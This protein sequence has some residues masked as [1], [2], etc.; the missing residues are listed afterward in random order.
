MIGVF[1]TAS[2]KVEELPFDLRPKRLMT[3]QLTASDDKAKVRAKLVDALAA[4]IKQCIGDTE[5]DRIRRNSRI[6]SV[7]SELW[8]FG[9]EIEEWYGIR[10]LPE[11]IQNQLSAAQELPD[12]MRRSTYAEML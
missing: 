7:L 1:N 3:Y 4:A 10:N 6:H 2:G 12:L 8:L 5:D 11:V 9:T